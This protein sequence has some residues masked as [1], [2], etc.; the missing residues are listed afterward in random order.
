MVGA[1][2]KEAGVA[3]YE[4]E[5]EIEAS[6]ERVWQALIHETNAW[7]LPDFH[8]VGPGSTVAFDPRAGGG[9]IET[10]PDGGSLLW[11]TVHWIRPTE[12]MIYLVGHFSPD[13]GGPTTSNLKLAVEPLGAGSVLKVTDAHHGNID[14]GNLDSLQSGWTTLFTDGMK[15]FIEDGVRRDG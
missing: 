12:R 13:F 4:L 1:K 5:V 7:W 8:M 9:L 2:K 15:R 11:C 3:L 6:P 10:L 14:D